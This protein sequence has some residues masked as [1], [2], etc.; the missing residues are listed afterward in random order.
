MWSITSESSDNKIWLWSITDE[1]DKLKYINTFEQHTDS[2]NSVAFSPLGNLLASGNDD[3]T[4]RLWSV[5]E[6]GLCLKHT[7]RDQTPS[8]SEDTYSI[9]SVAFNSLGN[10]LA[11]GIGDKTVQL[12]SITD[13]EPQYKYTFCGGHTGSVLSIV[14]SPSENLLVSGSYDKTILLWSIKNLIYKHE[15]TL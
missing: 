8:I 5:T 7:L 9:H 4:T 11:F 1:S 3:K 15:G 12:W 6:S 14:F 10:L 2:V 13:T